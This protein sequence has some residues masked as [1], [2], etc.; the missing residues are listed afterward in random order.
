MVVYWEYTSIGNALP[1][2]LLLYL[3][4]RCARMRARPWRLLLASAM[5]GA[6]AVIFPLL[7]LPVWAAYAVK[8]LGGVAI[9]LVAASGRRFASYCV[10]V[11]A[12]FALTFAMGG[13][14]TAVY[15][16]FDIETTA[17]TG[18][19][20]ERAPVSLVIT[21]FGIFAVLVTAAAR[22]FWKYRRMQRNIFAC[23]LSAGDCSV[24]WQGFADSGNC[25]SF[26]GEPVCVISAAGA[27]ALFGAH[28]RARADAFAL[29]DKAMAGA[30]VFGAKHYTFHGITRLKKNSVPADAG[31]LAASL[32][33]IAAA[34][35]RHGI[36]LSLENVH[37]ALYNAPGLFRPLKERC[38]AL[39]GV[40]DVKQARLSGY[41]YPMYIKDMEGSISHVHLSDVDER[42]RICLPGR[43][44]FDFV[45][46]FRRLKDAG[47]CG[48]ALIE[49]YAGD[50]G[51]YAELKRSCDFLGEA[52]AKA[53]L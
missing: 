11:A 6:F 13:L 40:L 48:T 38:P 30:A 33:E 12:F 1:D 21:G 51:E 45:E 44:V 2:G 52:A 49:V 9:A 47:F 25:L 5:G 3:A 10:E 43:G 14:L 46:C 19:Y 42:G 8:L 35:A 34:C 4:V 15:S 50:Y 32:G 26:R 31:K 7:K 23:E 16:F 27:F 20:L 41:P 29:L 22:A 28:P 24:R 17:G 36:G 39:S 53:G 37:W 18:F